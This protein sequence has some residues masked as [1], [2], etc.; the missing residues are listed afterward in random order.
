MCSL[1]PCCKPCSTSRTSQ[2]RIVPVCLT[3][4]IELKFCEKLFIAVHASVRMAMPLI[5]VF[6]DSFPCCKPCPTSRTSQIRFVPVCLAMLIELSFGEEFFIA[7]HASVR[8]ILIFSLYYVRPFALFATSAK[9]VSK[10]S[11]DCLEALFMF[12]L[13]C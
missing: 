3:M 11:N 10:M 2:I 12:F 9:S 4:L 6:V 13:M 8:L 7:V 1:I 5:H